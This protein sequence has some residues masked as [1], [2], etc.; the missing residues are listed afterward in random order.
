MNEYIKINN[1]ATL[2]FVKER[3]SAIISL[4]KETRD[5]KVKAAE[6]AYNALSLFGKLWHRFILS[7]FSFRKG[8]WNELMDAQYC[9]S[10]IYEEQ[11]QYC[12][13]TIRLLETGARTQLT[14]SSRQASFLQLD[15]LWNKTTKFKK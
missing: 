11:L 9:H 8:K 4:I 14:L 10:W 2:K 3:A 6:N 15:D 7:F 1:P 5:A 13:E 12:V